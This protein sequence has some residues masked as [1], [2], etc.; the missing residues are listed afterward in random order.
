M[1]FIIETNDYPDSFDLRAQ[2]RARHYA[3]LLNH[4]SKL[5]ASGGLKDNQGRICGG[6]II[7][8]VAQRFDA[9][10]FVKNDPFTQ[11]G[12]FE[13]VSI[14]DWFCAFWGGEDIRSI[15]R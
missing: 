1:P 2:W 12:L 15:A 14:Q 11:A 8:D 13:R 5:L 9:E 3:Y 10:A 4:Q 7:L 6:L